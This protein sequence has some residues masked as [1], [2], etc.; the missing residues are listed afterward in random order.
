MEAF[1][2]ADGFDLPPSDEYT[3]ESVY[4]NPTDQDQEAMAVMYLYLRD[5]EFTRPS[6]R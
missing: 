3:L 5:D 4:D 6:L 2:S 1:S